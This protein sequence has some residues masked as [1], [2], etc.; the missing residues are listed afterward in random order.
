MDGAFLG[1]SADINAATGR[2]LE[3]LPI[4]GVPEVQIV[5]SRSGRGEVGASRLRAVLF[6]DAELAE[7]VVPDDPAVFG[8]AT[9]RGATA[10]A[11]TT[12]SGRSCPSRY[13][14]PGGSVKV[15]YDADGR[16][17]PKSRQTR[18]VPQV[19]GTDGGNTTFFGV[20]TPADP[21]D[22]PNFFGTS[23]AAP[24]VAGI[25]ALAVQ[26]AAEQGRTL[27]PDALRARL[28]DATF[29]HDR[30]PVRV[31]GTAG[32]VVLTRPGAQSPE[33]GL[34]PGSMTDPHFF[35]AAQPQRHDGAVGDAGR[36]HRRPD[37]PRARA[38]PRASAGVVFDPRPYDPEAPRGEVGFPF[39]VGGTGGGL[40]ASTV[41][42]SY[43]GPTGTDS[44][45]GSP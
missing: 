29:A 8:H 34:T 26:R 23:A 12:R 7:H 9:A 3:L 2:P 5:V 15:L 40:K 36:D 20:D 11:R 31:D 25:A 39:T 14:A 13:T 18:T 33:T 42:A 30:D 35:T 4:S 22:Q 38:L 1:D 37:R 6:G 24:H 19:A 17:L 27:S 45:A 41:T 32:G 28:E 16:R 44:S 43:A 10:V 21:D